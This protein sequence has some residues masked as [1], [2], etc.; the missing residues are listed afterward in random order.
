MSIN[1]IIYTTV[2]RISNDVSGENRRVKYNALII[3]CPK[4]CVLLCYIN[5]TKRKRD[6]GLCSL[7]KIGVRH[8][9]EETL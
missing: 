8:C 5:D 4:H 3:E 7:L 2:T 1:E 9:T 6:A